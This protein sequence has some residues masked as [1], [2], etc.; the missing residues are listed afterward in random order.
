[1]EK[2]RADTNSRLKN[3]CFQ[4]NLRLIIRVSRSYILIER[5]T[6]SSQKICL[7][8]NNRI[9]NYEGDLFSEENCVSN[10]STFSQSDVKKALKDVRISNMNKLIFG[11]LN[12]NSSRNKF[13]LRS[14]QVK[15]SIDILMVSET[16]LGDSFPEGQFLIEDFHS[17]FRFDR[18][19]NGGR[20]MLYVQED[21]PSK[22]LS[23]DFPCVESFFVEINLYKKKWLINC[24]YNRHKINIENHLDIISRS[25][26]THSTKYENIVLLGDFNACVDDE[27]LQTFCKSDFFNSLIKQPPCFENPKSPSCIDLILTNKPRSFQTKCAIGTGLSDFHRMT[28]SVLKMNFRKLLPRF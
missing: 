16:K 26:D 8:L 17:P 5:V 25:L 20:I 4:K 7:I 10:D 21:I 3:Y 28:I 18:N 11:H 2:L 6:V 12:S 1:M 27:D 24:S 19:R 13:D 9:F 14:E 22:L 23:H 15:G